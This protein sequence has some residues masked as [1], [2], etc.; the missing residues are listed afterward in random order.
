MKPSLFVFGLIISAQISIIKGACN[1]NN[2]KTEH[3]ENNCECGQNR[4]KFQD[5]DKKYCCVPSKSTCEEI[6][7]NKWCKDGQLL[8]NYQPCNGSCLDRWQE[9][10]PQ[11]N[12]ASFTTEQCYIKG[13][14]GADKYQCLNRKNIAE[15]VIANKAVVEVTSKISKRFNLLEYLESYN[16]TF[17]KCKSQNNQTLEKVCGLEEFWRSKRNDAISCK[18]NHSNVVV[19]LSKGNICR[20][21]QFLQAMNYTQGN[22]SYVKKELYNNQ[23]KTGKIFLM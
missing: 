16:E 17:I 21:V 12:G 18:R 20:D 15:E 13:Y 22:I 2:G 11:I 8:P 10:C 23:D 3:F 14:L 19:Q 1:F 7:E 9:K 4:T 5:S 6:R